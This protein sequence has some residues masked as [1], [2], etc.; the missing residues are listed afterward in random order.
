MPYILVC[1]RC[2]N[3][4]DSE[5]QFRFC[6]QCGMLLK[7][8]YVKSE[9]PVHSPPDRE[10]LEIAKKV[11]NDYE[12]LRN[13][14]GDLELDMLNKINITSPSNRF[15]I[16]FL[17]T[18]FSAWAMR[19]ERAY[20]IWENLTEAYE[21]KPTTFYEYLINSKQPPI[22]TLRTNYGVPP[23][24][25]SNIWTTARNIKHVKG[26]IEGLKVEGDWYQT[27]EKLRDS[28]KGVNQKAFWIARVMRQKETW[29]IPGQ[30]CCVSDSH[31]IL[32]LSQLNVHHKIN[33]KTPQTSK[34]AENKPEND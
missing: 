33:K 27:I 29:D 13:E 30:Y 5:N 17:A 28:C 10:K 23:K 14:I 15:N 22:K 20:S 8:K 9:K 32:K 31:N 25:T 7:Q 34:I 11:Y 24:V 6:P 16:V 21:Q 26:D 4:Y 1:S 19:E 18:L 3:Q 12:S 2:N